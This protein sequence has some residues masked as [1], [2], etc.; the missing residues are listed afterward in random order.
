MSSPNTKYPKVAGYRLLKR[1]GGGAFSTVYQAFNEAEGKTAACKHLQ[2]QSDTERKT[3]EKEMRIHANLKYRHVLEFINA[4][5]VDPKKAM[6]YVPGIYMLLELAS[7]GDLF[8]KIVPDQGLDITTTHLYF[9]QLLDGMAYIHDQ[10]VCHRDLKPENILLDITGVLK[11]SDFGLSSVFKLKDSGKTRMLTERCGSLPYVAPELN[12]DQ[13]YQAEPVDVWGVGVIFYTL[14]VGNT[15][16]DEPT[17]N[18]VEFRDYMSGKLFTQEPWQSKILSV[19]RTTAHE[20][21]TGLLTVDPSQRLTIAQAQ[22]HSFVLHPSQLSDDPRVLANRLTQGLKEA[23]DMDVANPNFGTDPDGDAMMQSGSLSQFTQ[24]LMLFSQSQHGTK[25]DPY[26]TRFYARI[27]PLELM[28][29]VHQSLT[30]LGVTCREPEQQ[31]TMLRLR[32]GGRD[33][34]KLCFKG[35]VNIEPFMYGGSPGSFCSMQRDEGN[36]ISWRQLWKALIT[37]PDVK[38]YVITK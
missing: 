20:L 27:P 7:G 12:S 37:S 15:P 24:Q 10:G 14:L 21:L 3:F 19:G 6:N 34:R 23:G 31:T 11:I 30:G 22:T 18:S 13:P 36:P 32:V 26:L 28:Q 9:Q 1:I 16:W 29:L 25:Y 17:E 38:P 35:W 8:D 2:P 33:M 4:V 5:V